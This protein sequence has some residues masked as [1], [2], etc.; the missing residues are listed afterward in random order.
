MPDY[1]TSAI[2]AGVSQ[3]LDDITRTYQN[4][5]IADSIVRVNPEILAGLQMSKEQFGG[6]SAADRSSAVTGAITSIGIKAK[7]LQ[8][9]QQQAQ[10]AAAARVTAGT[11]GVNNDLSTLLT[12]PNAPQAAPAPVLPQPGGQPAQITPGIPLPPAASP[13][14]LIAPGLLPPG[15]GAPAAQPGITAA[16]LN[17]LP[18]ASAAPTMAPGILPQPSPNFRQALIQSGANNGMIGTP[19]FDKTLAAAERFDP[20]RFA[21]NNPSQFDTQDLGNGFKAVTK[22]GSK[23]FQIVSSGGQQVQIQNA[24]DA[25]GNAYGFVTDPKTGKVTILPPTQ[26]S[27]NNEADMDA[28]TRAETSLQGIDKQIRSYQNQVTL[29]KSDP[30]TYP[31][32]D[33]D[34]LTDLQQRRGLI[35]AAMTKAA[36]PGA[37]SAVAS[38][39]AA[40]PPAAKALMDRAQAAIQSG[41]DPSAVKALLAQKLKAIGFAPAQ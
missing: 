11:A 32:P 39:G 8:L 35:R 17:S 6:M 34:T 38:S 24:T 7:Q 20:G 13:A 15:A 40:V 4:G 23:E 28:M 2:P 10:I 21:D 25:Q 18:P 3:G 29:N 30:K 37:A 31:L 33:P 9:Q 27:K 14:P 26:G 19:E 5:K 12:Q 22:R 1:D 41:K 36:Q 16:M